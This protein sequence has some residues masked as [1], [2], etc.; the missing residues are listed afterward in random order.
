MNCALTY[1]LTNH[2]G[3]NSL[4]V[5]SIGTPLSEMR[6]KPAPFTLFGGAPLLSESWDRDKAPHPTLSRSGEGI[7]FDIAPV[8]R[9]LRG[10]GGKRFYGY[11]RL[12]VS[13]TN[14][15]DRKVHKSL[16]ELLSQLTQFIFIDHIY[17]QRPGFFQF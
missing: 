16:A 4:V 8:F 5:D 15:L 9:K 12:V 1:L 14:D 10:I 2:L 7:R 13:P 17:T 6:N 11:F 3:S